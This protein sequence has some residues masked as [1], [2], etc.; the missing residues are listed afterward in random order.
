MPGPREFPDPASAPM[1]TS[2]LAGER[3]EDWGRG[4]LDM[5]LREEFSPLDGEMAR[6]VTAMPEEDRPS[7]EPTGLQV[8]E[9]R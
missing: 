5:G 6:A 3:N 1:P 9:W 7:S 8:V 4:Y 2:T